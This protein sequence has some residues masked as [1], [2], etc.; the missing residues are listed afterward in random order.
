MH[1]FQV[2]GIQELQQYVSNVGGVRVWIQQEPVVAMAYE[3]WHATNRRRY[4]GSSAS[5]A[6]EQNRR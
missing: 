6:L 5:H 3:F 1:F 4:D 2:S